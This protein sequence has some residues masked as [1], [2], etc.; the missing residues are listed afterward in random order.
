[1]TPGLKEINQYSQSIKQL[2]QRAACLCRFFLQLQTNIMTV[3]GEAVNLLQAE[4]GLTSLTPPPEPWRQQET[5]GIVSA[6]ALAVT[7]A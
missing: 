6:L 2:R 4:R 3:G 7:E 5:H 1:M